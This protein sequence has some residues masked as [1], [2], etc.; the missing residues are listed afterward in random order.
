MPN[1]LPW[2]IF[3]W[4]HSCW[5]GNG[6]LPPICNRK[7]GVC[8]NAS[9]LNRVGAAVQYLAAR[10][11]E[12][13]YNVDTAP[14]LNWTT[15][16]IPAVSQMVQYLGDV[17]RIR[18]GFHGVQALPESMRKLDWKNANNIEKALAEVDE[19]LTR[20]IAATVAQCGITYCGVRI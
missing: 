20:M 3:W 10:L 16:G 6:L 4:G 9:D 17:R 5:G 8:Y 7:P 11:H 2:G 1:I 13:G 15:M 18:D 19:L 12:N 14:K